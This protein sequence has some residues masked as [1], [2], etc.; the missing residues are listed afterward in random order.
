MKKGKD[1]AN[2][3][4]NV[5]LALKLKKDWSKYRTLYLLFLPILVYYIIFQYGPMF[6]LVI[7]FQNYKPRLG[8]LKSP[9]V[10]LEH[11]KNLASVF[12]P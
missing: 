6:G 3:V 1:K 4:A 8:F 5:P 10:G 11:F 12:L 7:A 9:F 2:V